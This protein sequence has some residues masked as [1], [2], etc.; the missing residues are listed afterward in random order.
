MDPQRYTPIQL[1][2]DI[3]V[4][5]P[6]VLTQRNDNVTQIPNF[7]IDLFDIGD[8]N[9]C[10]YSYCCIGCALAQSRTYLDESNCI[11]NYF[12][13]PLIPFRWMVRSSYGIGSKDEW[14]EDCALS[15]FCPCCVVN[16]LYQTTQRFGNPT[17]D[18]GRQ[19][20]SYPWV[21]SSIT[22]STS[23][24][25]LFVKFLKSC[26]CMP[27][28]IAESL[29]RSIGLPCVLGCFC[30]NLCFAHNVIRYQFRIKNET[31][32][33]MEDECVMYLSLSA[34]NCLGTLCV[35]VA[36]CLPCIDWLVMSTYVLR[37]LSGKFFLHLI[38][39]AF[40][41]NHCVVLF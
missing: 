35:P 32:F 30:G 6:I 19:K 24:S 37:I 36:Q 21:A 5:E 9:S 22:N 41:N 4:V 13:T 23:K 12:F 29:E 7:K 34:F 38:I 27:C 39:M 31:N 28:T 10:L 8:L 1:Q 40:N 11:F 15:I 17:S 25:D 33:P 16:Q 3:I 2:D 14:I 20:N 26:C 18:G